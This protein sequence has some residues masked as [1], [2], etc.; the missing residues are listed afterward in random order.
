M[1]MD[2]RSFLQAAGSAAL[3][4]GLGMPPGRPLPRQRIKAVAFDAFPIFDARSISA[5]AEQL[6]PGHGAAL[7]NLWRARQFEYQWLR[8]LSGN[9]ADFWQTTE[10]SLRFACQA[11]G[12][13][14]K[15]GTRRA[16]IETCL[17]LKAWPEVPGAL[18]TLRQAG[19]RLA[20]LSN[21]T[22]SMLQANIRSAGLDGM[23]D[24]VLS[25]DTIRSYKPDPRAYRLGMDALRL[26]REEILFAAFAGWDAAG[27]K[28]FGYPTFWVNRAQAPAEM[29]G[30]APD[31][32]GR[33]LGELAAYVLARP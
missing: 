25:S 14:T 21:M 22:R 19:M 17:T 10:D 3:A 12:L 30:V 31:R 32:V 33:D 15:A 16:L 28:A 20:L 27:A 29:L 1:G 2:R 9:Y 24:H 4:G 18:R 11:L 13:E 26:R 6:F 5:L 8:A 7:T 23:F